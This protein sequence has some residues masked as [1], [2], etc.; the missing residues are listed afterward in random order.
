MQGSR[1]TL[2]AEKK[3]DHYSSLSFALQHKLRAK[4]GQKRKGGGDYPTPRHGQR[5]WSGFCH[6]EKL[7]RLEKLYIGA[8]TVFVQ[9][10]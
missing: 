7:D 6:P 8:Q 3:Q 5:L 1:Q 10:V 9:L 2:Y 4:Q